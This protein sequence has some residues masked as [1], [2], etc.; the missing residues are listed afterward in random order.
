ML[1]QG[2]IPVHLNGLVVRLQA[3]GGLKV[4]CSC[5]QLAHVQS[6]CATAVERLHIPSI[7]QE[8]CSA[9]LVNLLILFLF[10][11]CHCSVGKCD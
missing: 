4:H 1:C 5:Q 8:G 2:I 3:E 11:Q 6:G 9:I 10:Q 7:Q